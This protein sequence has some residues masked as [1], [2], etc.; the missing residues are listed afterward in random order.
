MYPQTHQQNALPVLHYHLQPVPP[1]PRATPPLQ[2]LRLV[3]P[4]GKHVSI[5]PQC[6]ARTFGTNPPT[7]TTHVLYY[8]LKQFHMVGN[9]YEFQTSS[10][11]YPYGLDTASWI[12]SILA[13]QLYIAPKISLLFFTVLYYH[14][15]EHKSC[16]TFTINDIINNI[17]K[18]INYC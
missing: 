18:H 7:T 3:P 14:K 16:I 6:R 17:Y 2:R 11:A 1:Y 13:L 12:S 8:Y 4:L 10:Q 5:P 9:C 15:L